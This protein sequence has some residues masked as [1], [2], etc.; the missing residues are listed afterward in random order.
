[1][2]KMCVNLS[3]LPRCFDIFPTEASIASVVRDFCGDNSA[4][5]ARRSFGFRDRA[6]RYLLNPSFNGP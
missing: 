2:T 4:I 3:Q 6:Y 1:V 5:L